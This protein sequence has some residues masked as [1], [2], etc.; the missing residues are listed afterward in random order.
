M[1]EIDPK[2]SFARASNAGEKFGEILGNV[3]RKNSVFFI[4]G[5][6]TVFVAVL[7]FLG[8]FFVGLLKKSD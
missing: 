8:R 3:I 7:L 4:V 1:S 5:G 2:E 6:I